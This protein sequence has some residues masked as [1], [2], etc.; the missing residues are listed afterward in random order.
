MTAHPALK[1]LDD[2]PVPDVPG[3]VRAFLVVRNETLRLPDN[4]RHHRGRG[5][6][7]FFIVD[8]G[9]T[10][11]TV[12][13]LRQQP[14]VHLFSTEASFGASAFGMDWLNALL[15]RHGNG[16]WCLTVDADELLI[17]PGFEEVALPR[18]CGHLD[19]RGG[20]GLFCLLLDMYADAPLAALRHAP[21]GSLL[22]ACPWFDRAP[23]RTVE[24]A[25]CPPCRSMAACAN[26]FSLLAARRPPSARSPW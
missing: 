15:D 21:G 9:S 11:G 22:E 4:L 1:S 5:V 18:L 23:Y 20:Q 13:F 16:H 24:V 7:R 26:G 2:R 3:E 17:Y 19:S 14:D 10:D 6:G 12:E 25:A 8:N